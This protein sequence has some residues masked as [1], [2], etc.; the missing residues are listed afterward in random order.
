MTRFDGPNLSKVGLF[1]DD[2][3]DSDLTKLIMKKMTGK[4]SSFMN[5]KDYVDQANSVKTANELQNT[6]IA[7]E[8]AEWTFNKIIEEVEAIFEYDKQVKHSHI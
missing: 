6:K 1:L 7:S 5:M 2:K 8:F 4:G 3:E